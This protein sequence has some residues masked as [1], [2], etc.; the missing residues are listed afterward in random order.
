MLVFKLTKH[1]DIPFFYNPSW[2]LYPA[3]FFVV[4]ASKPFIHQI[5]GT[6]DVIESFSVI[7][8]SGGPWLLRG[9][10]PPVLP[11]KKWK[12]PFQVKSWEE[13]CGGR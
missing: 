6:T 7:T 8:D 3:T 11:T 1:F 9:K 13:L 5:V 2:W 10:L 12:A 4:L